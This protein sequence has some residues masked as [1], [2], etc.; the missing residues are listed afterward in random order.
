MGI[1]SKIL[2]PVISF[3][4]N[5]GLIVGVLGEIG[6][7]CTDVPEYCDNYAIREIENTKHFNGTDSV[8]TMN[9]FQIRL[10]SN[11]DD[12]DAMLKAGKQLPKSDTTISVVD[13]KRYASISK[14]YEIPVNAARDHNLHDITFWEKH[15]AIYRGVAQILNQ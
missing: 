14:R 1:A 10:V 4:I 12:G 8:Y 2:T 3:G 7:Q 13:G 15:T 9:N 6:T 5:A 11:C